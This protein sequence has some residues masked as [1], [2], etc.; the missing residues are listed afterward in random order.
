M[1][2]VVVSFHQVKSCTVFVS[3]INE[4]TRLKRTRE[5]FLP[6][7]KSRKQVEWCKYLTNLVQNATCRIFQYNFEVPRV[8]VLENIPLFMLFGYKKNLLLM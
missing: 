6:N 5:G 4:E 7:I 2:L 8:R 3:M 1:I